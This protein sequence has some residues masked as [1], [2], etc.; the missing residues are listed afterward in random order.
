MS[1]RFLGVFNKDY[2]MKF[3]L[4][5]LRETMARFGTYEHFNCDRTSPPPAEELAR[6]VAS[7]DV[8]LTGWG[9]PMLPES[10]LTAPSRQLRYICHVA[11]QVSPFL[12]RKFLESDIRVTNWGEA[13]VWTFAEGTVA[14]IFGCLKD[15]HRVLPFM[16]ANHWGFTFS[17]PSPTLRGKTIGLIGFGAIART[18]VEMLRPFECRFVWF[19]PFASGSTAANDGRRG[20][21]EEV[22]AEADIVSVHCGLTPQ[23]TGMIGLAQFRKMKPHAILVNTS[24]GKVIRE[25]ELVQFLRERPDVTAG[26]DV[27]ET[28]PLPADSPL[29]QLD[30]AICYSHCV[31]SGGEVFDR[32][33][34][35]IAAANIE[36]FCTGRPMQ[37]VISPE[38]FDRMT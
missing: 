26:L 17:R 11:G 38:Q 21:L 13:G 24:R 32:L 2:E 15:M 7:A 25:A 37:Y 36:A 12:T 34:C 35:H 28:E 8:I 18:V 16:Q 27:Y 4:E 22:F 23:T 1:T 3:V 33:V 5:E 19:D 20:T 6:R 14:L 9:T 10:I 29:P 31:G 30:N